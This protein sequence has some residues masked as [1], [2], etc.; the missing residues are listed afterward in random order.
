MKKSHFSSLILGLGIFILLPL[1]SFTNTNFNN[2]ENSKKVGLYVIM[3]AKPERA[4]ELK[5]FLFSGLELAHKEAGTKTWYAFQVDAT[6]FGIFDTFTD[7]E[8]RNA[9]L[10]GDIAKALLSNA[11]ELLVDFEVSDIKKLDIIAAK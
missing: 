7:E 1:Y 4:D 11:E 5:Q 6:T 2:M 10:S 9:H 3:N 8:G